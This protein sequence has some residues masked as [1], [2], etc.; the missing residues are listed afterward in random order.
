MEGCAAGEKAPSSLRTLS[1]VEREPHAYDRRQR[2]M[3]IRGRGG[4]GRMTIL[5][6]GIM[7]GTLW[8]E[9]GLTGYFIPGRVD[10]GSGILEISVVVSSGMAKVSIPKLASKHFLEGLC[11]NLPNK[12]EPPTIFERVYIG[13]GGTSFWI[14]IKRFLKAVPR[15]FCL[16]RALRSSSIVGLWGTY[17][18]AVP[19]QLNI[20]SEIAWN[21]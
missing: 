20:L 19:N 4:T 15:Q 17:C 3:G 13:R 18:C 8:S 9:R 12:R 14:C 2:Q 1:R 16:F 10:T 21:I 11:A 5:E 7:G 6:A